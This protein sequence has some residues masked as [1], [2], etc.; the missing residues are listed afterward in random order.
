VSPFGLSIIATFEKFESEVYID[1]AGHPTIGFGHLILEGEDFPN[2]LTEAEA[3]K[4]LEMDVRAAE[5]AVERQVGGRIPDHP[6]RFEA[7][8]SWTFNLGEGNLQASTM[9]R[10]LKEGADD[11]DV[12]REMIRWVHAGGKRLSGLVRRRHCEAV[13]FLGAPED[14]VRYLAEL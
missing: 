3:Y 2:A 7:L 11:E 6:W 5:N 10:Y 4:I 8:V 1:A 13:W 12:A 14:T 9:L